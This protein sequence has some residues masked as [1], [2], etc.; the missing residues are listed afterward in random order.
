ME[1]RDKRHSE[2][3]IDEWTCINR[4]DIP[5]QENGSDCGVFTCMVSVSLYPPYTVYV[6]ASLN[7]LSS[8]L[9]SMPDICPVVHHLSSL[10]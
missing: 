7:Y 1:S 5:C 10:K 9:Y 6:V 2:Y 4:S 8:R 3:S